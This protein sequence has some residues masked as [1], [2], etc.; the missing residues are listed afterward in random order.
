MAEGTELERLVIRLVGDGKSYKQVL[1]TAVRD[2][3]KTVKDIESQVK[4]AVSAQNRALAEGAA[5]TDALK[6]ST[7]VYGET[8]RDLDNLLQRGA[9]SQDIYNRA[10]Q[11]ARLNLPEVQAAQA[12]MNAETL[13]ARQITEAVLTPQEKYERNV[14]ELSGLLKTGKVTQETYNRAVRELSKELPEVQQAQERVR[15]AQE[16]QNDAIRLG[17]QLTESLRSPTERYGNTV[18][19]VENLLRRG[20]ISQGTYNRAIK[21]ARSEL[22]AARAAQQKYDQ[23]LQRARQITASLKTPTQ[24]YQKRLK[25]LNNLQKL[26]LISTATY[27]RAQKQLGQEFAVVAKRMATVGN[28][29]QSVGASM[30]SMGRRM[31]L[32]VTAPIVGFGALSVRSFGQFDQ[33]MT[34]SL[35]IMQGVTPQIRRQMEDVAKAISGRSI[36][37]PQD[38]AESYFFLASAGLSAEQSVG[39][40]G[41]VERF[42]V[43]GAF[44]MATATDLLTDAQ[45]ALGLQSKDTERNL[46]GLVRISDVLARGNEL[47]NATIQQFSESLTND[48]AVAAKVMSIELETQVA[49]LSA[50]ASQGKKGAEA[51]SLLGRAI[52]LT[53]NAFNENAKE[54]ERRGIK[55]VDEATGQY[56]N[57]ID[58][59][60]DLENSFKDLTGPQRVAALEQ[61]GF[62]ALAQKSILPLVGMSKAM[63]EW[64]KQLKAAGGTTDRI[65]DKQLKSFNN[66][67]TILLNNVR[68]VGIEIGGLLAPFILRVND[69]IKRGLKFWSELNDNTKLWIIGIAGVLAAAGPLL[70][71]LGLVVGVVGGIIAAIAGFLA[72]G[73]EVIFVAAAI[74]VGLAIMAAEFAAVATAIGFAIFKLVG[75]DSLKSAWDSVLERAK[76]FFTNVVGFFSNFSANFEILTNFIRDNW[77]G[78]INDMG[79]LF[80]VFLVNMGKNAVVGTRLVFRLFVAWQGSMIALFERIFTIE[81]VKF[82]GQG[83]VKGINLMVGFQKKSAEILASIFTGEEVDVSEFISGIG[84]DFDV[85]RQEGFLKAAGAI[86]KEELSNLKAPFEGFES[87]IADLPEFIFETGK[88]IGGALNKGVKAG[89]AGAED[90]EVPSFA[91]LTEE[92]KKLI[93]Q[94]DTLNK[95]LEQQVSL[96][97]FS[98]RELEIQKLLLKGVKDESLILTRVLDQQLTAMEKQKTLMEKGKQVT[99]QFKT[100]QEKFADR[101]KELQE[102]FDAGAI[103]VDTFDRA[104]KKAREGIDKVKPVKFKV[105]GIQAVESGTAEAIARLEEFQSRAIKTSNVPILKDLGQVGTIPGAEKLEGIGDRIR[106]SILPDVNFG[107]AQELPEEQEDQGET[108]D[109]LETILGLIETNTDP[110]NPDNPVPVVIEPAN[111]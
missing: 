66:Q 60:G 110:R 57:F 23:E 73:L 54:F 47:A 97:G 99:D 68:L 10:L 25:E 51:G 77:R 91:G 62:A 109:A 12:R 17:K 96:F 108:L 29:V 111:I 24:Q 7:E 5:I 48:A 32:F 56:R 86:L 67:M 79:R 55:V 31:A 103:N 36:T 98:G 81:F 18:K 40:L 80:Q 105:E 49:L 106:E 100:S 64:E 15:K 107:P 38:L 58:V 42:A 27:R 26:G 104:L 9:I 95:S 33:A 83:I 85:G 4:A 87:A 82:I 3:E 20:A 94:V 21:Q 2:T 75:A 8:V 41:K 76:N 37:A 14:K 101:Q 22:P 53:T 43:A 74:A 89:Q 63:K 88:E 13:R 71:I 59:I 92:E 61:L 72:I 50:Y 19:E 28:R 1:E 69:I 90:I 70:V 65:A 93:L 6:T 44:D 16:K 39:A 35:S 34:R 46:R 78:I 45:T 102:L 84:E 11:E 30:T 52:R